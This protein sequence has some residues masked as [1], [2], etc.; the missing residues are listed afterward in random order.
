M[1]PGFRVW[2][3]LHLYDDAQCLLLLL[4]EE[5]HQVITI[6][7]RLQV[8]HVCGADAHPVVIGKRYI[9]PVQQIRRRVGAVA[10]EEHQQLVHIGHHGG[11][12]TT[13]CPSRS[14]HLKRGNE[15]K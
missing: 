7:G 10:E 12:K 1:P 9:E 2:L 4:L 15:Q 14:A 3:Q 5:Q 6:L 11:E 8:I 13:P